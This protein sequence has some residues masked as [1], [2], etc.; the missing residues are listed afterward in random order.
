MNDEIGSAPRKNIDFVSYS[1][2][3][4]RGDGVQIMVHKGHAYIGHMFSNGVTILDVA[5]PKHPRP[6][7][8]LLTP[9]NTWSLHLQAYG[10]L[11]LVVNAVN[12]YSE[13]I[14]IDKTEYYSQSFADTFGKQQLEFAAGMR[15]YDISQPAQPREIGFMPVEGYGLHRLAHGLYGPYFY[16]YRYG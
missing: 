12:I 9:P 5:D 6:V 8:F 11:L 16:R 3:G 13:N 7:N 14:H 15:V 2:Q 1:D 4:G 10:D